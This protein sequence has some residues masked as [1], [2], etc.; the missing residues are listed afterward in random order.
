MRGGHGKPFDPM[1]GPGDKRLKM[2]KGK[3]SSDIYRTLA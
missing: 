2:E 1:L 3:K